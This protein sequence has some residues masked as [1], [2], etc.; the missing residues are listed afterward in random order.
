MATPDV[1]QISHIARLA[2]LAM[3]A[4]GVAAVEFDTAPEIASVHVT[5]CRT[6]G[7]IQEMT[8]DLEYISIGGHV[9]GGISL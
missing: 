4:R 2:V 9:I 8:V 6:D 5:V 7:D 3:C 1:Q